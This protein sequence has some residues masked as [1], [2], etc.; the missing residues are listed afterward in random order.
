M[1]KELGSEYVIIGHSERR[2]A[3]KEG[4]QLLLD[5]LN[6]ASQEG[7]KVIFCIGESSKQK[8]QDET[9]EVLNKQLEIVDKAKMNE[10]MI[11]YEPIWAIG[12]GQTAKR[13]DVKYIHKK[14]IEEVNSFE[15]KG[16]L[17]VSYGGSVDA[18]SSKDFIAIEE[19]Q[20]LLIGGASLK[21][22]DFCN[23][24]LNSGQN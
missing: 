3:F 13:S 20:G 24:V 10:F 11:A 15:K 22:E 21:Y 6:S 8:E 16:F 12:S 17:G 19:V 5:K 1:L 18:S 7:L 2:E 9:L 14:I 4:N 23:I